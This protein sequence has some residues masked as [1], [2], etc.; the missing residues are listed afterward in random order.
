[1]KIRFVLADGTFIAGGDYFLP[2][3]IQNM[4]IL[5][6]YVPEG[7]KMMESGDF[8]VTEGGQEDITVEKINKDVI[9][10]IRFVLA[11]GTFIA[12]GDYFL[13]EG[14]QNMSI[15]EQYVPEGYKMMESGDFFVTEGG[16]EDITVEKIN[17]DVIMKIRFVLAD[18]T[19]SLAATTS[20]PRASRT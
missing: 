2:E 3:G 20:C 18:G 9:M 14:I 5:E 19:S 13:P 1:M 6:Q 15:L 16:Q 4:S 11:D 12:G 10:K 17:K 8:F 7:Y